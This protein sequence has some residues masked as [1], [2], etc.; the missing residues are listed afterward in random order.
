MKDDKIFEKD[1]VT[2][3]KKYI[4]GSWKKLFKIDYKIVIII[5]LSLLFLG[6]WR[7]EFSICQDVMNTVVNDPCS[8]C[9]ESLVFNIINNSDTNLKNNLTSENLSAFYEEIQRRPYKQ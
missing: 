8:Y 4:S 9:Q 7:T 2:G 1:P 5:V 6:A 3:K